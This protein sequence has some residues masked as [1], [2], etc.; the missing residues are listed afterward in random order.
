MHIWYFSQ[1]V[2]NITLKL[3]LIF[4]VKSNIRIDNMVQ[5]IKTAIRITDMFIIIIK[6]I[7]N[8]EFRKHFKGL[9]DF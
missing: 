2:R 7:I 3:L 8:I 9:D 4:F 6:I 1:I 5:K